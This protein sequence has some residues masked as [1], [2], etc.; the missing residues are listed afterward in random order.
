MADRI[1][2]GRASVFT[3]GCRLNQAESALIADGLERHGFQLVPWGEPCE[4]AVINSCTV[5]AAAA[6]KTRQTARALRRKQPGVYLVLAGCDAN[7]SAGTWV[8]DGTVDL[9]VPNPAKTRLFEYLP[10]ELVR[11]AVEVVEIEPG[12]WEGFTEP[13]I[14]AFGERTRANLKIQEGCE[15]FCSYCIVPYAR[16]PARSRDW[17]DWLREAKE[18]VARGYHEIVL[19]G[20]NIATYNHGGRDLADV[21]QALLEIP[22]DFRVRLSSTEPGPVLDRVIETMAGNPRVCRFLHLALQYGE[23]TILQAMNRRYTV[24]EYGEIATKAAEAVPGL[25]LGSDIIIGFPGETDGTF[26]TCCRNVR[27]LPINHLHV[28]TYSPRKGTPAATFPNQVPGDLATRR[29]EV[30]TNVGLSKAEAFARSQL[31]SVVKIIT[32]ERNTAG[33][34]EGWTDNY[35]RVELIGAD[36]GENEM[37]LR[38]T[39]RSRR[40]QTATWNHGEWRVSKTAVSVAAIASYDADQVLTAMRSALEPLGGLSAFVQPGQK[41]LLKPNLLGAFSPDE[42]VTTHPSVV[43]AAIILAQE[44]GGIVTVGD[45]PGTGELPAALR[46]SGVGA[47][48]DELG[49]AVADFAESADIE[50]Q[51]NVIG[52]RLAL[53]QAVTDADVVITLPKLKTHAQMGFTCALKN[54]FGLIVGTEKALWHYRLQDRDWLAALMIDINQ[55]AKPSLAIVDAIVGMEGE[56]P[57]GGQPRPI[58]ALVAGPDLS[59]VDAVCCDLVAIDP[60]SLPLMKAARR[61]GYGTVD[62]ADI[63]LHGT[64]LADVRVPDFKPPPKSYD[65]LEIIPMPRR[66]RSGLRRVLTARPEIDS[67]LCINCNACKNGCPIDPPAID[68]ERDNGGVDQST[69]IRCYCCH[70]FCPVKAIRLK[71]S[72]IDRVFH[73]NDLARWLAQTGERLRARKS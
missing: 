34:W 50:R 2:T 21:I 24:E 64:P 6:R 28:F 30:L 54:Q 8:E 1:W 33:N 4:L 69:C 40:G 20:V 45:S 25:C 38:S 9:V 14:G 3:L 5:T 48:V 13:G 72:W 59:A 56:G 71:R 16:G 37:G 60:A 10:D 53:A 32:E 55:L 7:V 66:F 73:V 43:R 70:E 67:S 12:D 23:N 65:I 15:F 19:T 62:I 18:L 36:P 35:L 11:G 49:V 31:G 42:A 39:H 58:G 51:E 52:R 29:A 41:V 17:D 44:A 27:D 57:S 26:D 61:V 68:P 46:R 22:G 47:V 63:D